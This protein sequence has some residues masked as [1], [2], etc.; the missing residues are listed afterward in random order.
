M[1]T[2]LS[3][4]IAAVLS[5]GSLFAQETIAETTF[6][7]RGNCPS[8]EKRI[9]K[10]LKKI[11][12]VQEAEWDQESGNVKVTYDSAQTNQESMEKAVAAVGHATKEHKAD[13][14]VHDK[15]PKCCREG[16]D[17]HHD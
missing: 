8:C 13:Q 17:K 12:G 2:L 3:L 9:E 14:V 1:K 6:W 15:L 7:V 16:Y 4:V 10:T 5:I 11:D